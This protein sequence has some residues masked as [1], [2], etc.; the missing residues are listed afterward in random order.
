MGV[1]GI[2]LM[3]VSTQQS[4]REAGNRLFLTRNRFLRYSV[5]GR[6]I[7]KELIK[8]N[9]IERQ[10]NVY[11]YLEIYQEQTNQDFYLYKW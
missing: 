3:K 1:G 4:I 11:C 10:P 5:D 6:V 9:S 7:M 8:L 2:G